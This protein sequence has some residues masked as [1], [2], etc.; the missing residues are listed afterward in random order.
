V[1]I[2]HST[3][4]RVQLTVGPLVRWP[5]QWFF[6]P[7]TR[8]LYH[9]EEHG[10]EVYQNPVS[11]RRTNRQWNSHCPLALPHAPGPL[12]AVAITSSSSPPLLLQEGRPSIVKPIP[13]PDEVPAPTTIHNHLQ[14]QEP[15]LRSSNVSIFSR[16][17]KLVTFILSAM[18]PMTPLLLL[19]LPHVS[20]GMVLAG[21]T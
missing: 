19:V 9:K 21:D 18:G 12:L 15:A 5:S 11:F 13:T 4:L 10:Y 6:H 7:P 17:F 3:G 1:V 14:S 2:L 20:F 8:A 16:L